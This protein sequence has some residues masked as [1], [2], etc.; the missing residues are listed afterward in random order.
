MSYDKDLKVGLNSN[1]D[2]LIQQLSHEVGELQLVI[3][4]K[5]DEGED[6]SSEG[7]RVKELTEQIDELRKQGR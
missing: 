3:F 7:A 5:E 1:N 6:T 2:H 4:D